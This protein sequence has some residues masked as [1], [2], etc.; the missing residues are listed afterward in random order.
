MKSVAF[1]CFAL[2]FAHAV[3]AEYP[4]RPIK[5]VMPFPPGGTVDVLTRLVSS[6]ASE[7]LGKP[8]VLD[9]RP[10][11]GG[12]IATEAVARSAP[13]GYTIL[14]ATPN[15]TINPALRSKLPF[16]TAH[17][18]VAVTL[19]A[20]IPELLVAHPA[21]PFDTLDGLLK[22]AKANPGKLSYSSAGIGT[23]PHIT[24]ELLLRSAG[25]QVTHV[26]YKGAAPAFTD[27]LGG[28]VQL[29]YDTYA[30][31]APMLANGKLKVLA[32]AGR[33]RLPQLPNVPT[34]AESGFPGYE[35]YLWIGALAPRGTPKEALAALSAALTKAARSPKVA[36]RFQADGVEVPP[37][38]PEA[39]SRLIDEELQLW[40]RVVREANIKVTD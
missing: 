29:K 20:N 28:V 21:V 14:V 30:T 6:D 31:S 27:L 13:D 8:L 17:D 19:F 2:L 38:G 5:V 16:D 9:Y 4:E 3:H 18:F 12:T 10:G 36:G 32:T 1:A 35:G 25:V 24:M 7:T 26:P 23:L 22:Y 39:F 34:V 11:A 33:Q 15:H 37:A 40:P